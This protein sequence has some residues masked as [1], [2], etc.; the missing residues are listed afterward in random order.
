M[1]WGIIEYLSPNILPLVGSISLYP[2]TLKQGMHKEQF[3]TASHIG[4]NGWCLSLE[5]LPEPSPA[6]RWALLAQLGR[7]V[8]L[9]GRV[10]FAFPS[11]SSSGLF[12]RVVPR[13]ACFPSS[14]P[15]PSSL[16]TNPPLLPPS[17]PLPFTPPPTPPHPPSPPSHHRL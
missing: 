13:L 7:S 14:S 3:Q 1:L 12:F 16:F 6:R 15:L 4:P 11:F 5:F 2:L 9:S 8:R 17:F 10:H